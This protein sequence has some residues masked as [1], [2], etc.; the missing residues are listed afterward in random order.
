MREGIIKN[1]TQNKGKK[2]EENVTKSGRKKNERSIN[3]SRFK[4]LY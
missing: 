4:L 2:G 1:V 3:D